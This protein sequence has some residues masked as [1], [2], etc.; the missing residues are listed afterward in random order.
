[1][2]NIYLA[3]VLILSVASFSS[4]KKDNHTDPGYAEIQ[5]EWELITRAGGLAGD[6]VKYSLGNGNAY[7]FKKEAYTK[8]T[9]QQTTKTGVYKVVQDS[10][11]VTRQPAARIVFDNDQTAVR[12]LVRFKNSR[13]FI[14]EDV[15]DG[16]TYEYRRI[17]YD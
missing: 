5:G 15:V 2:R 17:L 8:H 4:C 6:S 10:S 12:T 7:S 9:P 16:F 3:A 11:S 1:M 13:M 14:I